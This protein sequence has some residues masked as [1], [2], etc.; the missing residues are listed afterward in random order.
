MPLWVGLRTFCSRSRRETYGLQQ[1]GT[2]IMH[3]VA[4]IDPC[5]I[6]FELNGA[7]CVSM[8]RHCVYRCTKPDCNVADLQD[9]PRSLAENLGICKIELQ[10]GI[11]LSDVARVEAGPNQFPSS[12]SS[13]QSS[14]PRYRCGSSGGSRL[15]RET[16]NRMGFM[17]K[18][19]LFSRNRSHRPLK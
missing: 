16:K 3:E 7:T 18:T 17:L 5:Q 15:G 19:R 4:K 1:D 12:C 6:Q 10:C 11:N 8:C 14:P 13:F 9:S 2:Q